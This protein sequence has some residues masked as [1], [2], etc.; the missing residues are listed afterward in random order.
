MNVKNTTQNLESLK[1][2]IIEE[3]VKIPLEMIHKSTVSGL[4]INSFVLIM[5]TAILNEYWRIQIVF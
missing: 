2:S 5:K 1:Q 4:H 3:A